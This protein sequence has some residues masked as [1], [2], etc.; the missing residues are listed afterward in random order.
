MATEVKGYMLGATLQLLRKRNRPER[1]K[2]EYKIDRTDKCNT[3][4]QEK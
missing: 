3:F 1:K 4:N 2:E